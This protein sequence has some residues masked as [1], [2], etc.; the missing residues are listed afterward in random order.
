ML[1]FCDD[2]KLFLLIEKLYEYKRKR[3]I[4]LF[5]LMMAVEEVAMQ[6]TPVGDQMIWG[7]AL[8]EGVNKKSLATSP[9]TTGQLKVDMVR[10]K[11]LVTPHF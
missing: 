3:F 6:M 5:R 10:V 9:M 11:S 7:E 4:V 8:K 1:I 2:F